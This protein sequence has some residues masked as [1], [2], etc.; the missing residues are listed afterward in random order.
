MRVPALDPRAD[1]RRA[2]RLLPPHPVP[3]LGDVPHPPSAGAD[4]RGPARGRPGR[5]SHR[6]LRPALLLVGAADD[7]RVDRGGPDPLARA[8]GA[9]RR[10]PDGRR[11]GGAGGRSPPTRRCC[12]RRGP[13]AAARSGSWWASTGSTTPRAS[14]A[15]CSPT[16]SC[17]CDSPTS[18]S[19]SAS[20]RWRCRPAPAWASTRA[21]RGGGRARRAHQ[22]PVRD[23]H[24]V[25]GAL[26]LPRAVAQARWRRSTASADVLV[27]TPIARRDEPGGKG[28][29]RRADRRRRG[30]GP[31]RIHR[32][33][34]R[35]GGGA[36]GQPVRPRGHGRRAPPCAEHARPGAPRPDGAPPHQGR[37]LR[38]P[39]LGTRVPGPAGV[40]PGASARAPPLVAVGARGR[41]GADPRGA[42]GRPA[43]RLRRDAGGVRAHAGPRGPRSAA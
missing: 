30:A 7:R 38:R 19:R 28:V 31:L 26:P 32:R 2:H 11:C 35:A 5:L 12:R 10:L 29:R 23:A 1:P 39:P 16:S 33:G 40:G 18:A 42:L 24:L 6:G 14:P 36:P 34:G 9:P 27:V 20:S 13:C 21:T 37:D 41:P 17:C 8:G 3:L 4:P 25:A 22:R 15:G 43:P